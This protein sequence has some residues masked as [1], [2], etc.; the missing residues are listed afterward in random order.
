MFLHQLPQSCDLLHRCMSRFRL[1]SRAWM[2]LFFPL[3]SV[4]NGFWSNFQRDVCWFWSGAGRFVLKLLDMDLRTNLGTSAREFTSFSQIENLPELTV[5]AL[6]TTT[7]VHGESS[8][9]PFCLV[10]HS[11]VFTCF[12]VAP[13]RCSC[14]FSAGFLYSPCS[15]R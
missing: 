8:I 11:P 15:R 7:A 5:D 12:L 1:L 6:T 9:K 10:R 4:S 2:I 14:V 13:I 3:R